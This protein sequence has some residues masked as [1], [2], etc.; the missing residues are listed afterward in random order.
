MMK[1]KKLKFY[2]INQSLL[3][4]CR[5]KKKLAQY[6]HYDLKS[7]KKIISEI[8][9]HYNFFSKDK[10]NS[11]KKREIEA[12]SD[13]LKKIQKNILKYLKKIQK[14]NYVMSGTLGKSYIDNAKYHI[15]EKYFLKTDI[16]QFYK[17]CSR[18][19]VYRF[20]LDK[21]YTSPDVAE[22]LTNLTTYRNTIPT[23]APSSQL[24]AY[25]AYEDMFNNMYR[26]AKNN[27]FKMS[28]YVDDLVFS[29]NDYIDFKSF[30]REIEIEALKYNHSLKKSKTMYYS[31]KKAALVTGV[32]INKGE[33]KI[34]NRLR[35]NAVHQYRDIKNNFIDDKVLLSFIGN[36]NSAR[37]IEPNHFNGLLSFYKKN[38]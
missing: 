8:D 15:N 32:I 23:G 12:P 10:K 16:K 36:I 24:I 14:P 4:K 18:D 31:P 38:S 3:Y 11:D 33:L 30:L 21:M 26:K 1:K 34:P 22:I 6:L 20:F 25:F 5:S 13:E 27:G 35:N 29:R 9:S 17:N 19:R 28:L 7:L 37:L 2:N